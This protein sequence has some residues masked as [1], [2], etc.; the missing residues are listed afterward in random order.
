M[1]IIVQYN[2]LSNCYQCVFKTIGKQLVM[3]KFLNS[4]KQNVVI[5]QHKKINVSVNKNN[6][7][8]LYRLINL[9]VSV[10]RK[11]NIIATESFKYYFR[12]NKKL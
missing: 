7:D 6:K 5:C 3:I 4:L 12:A 8:Y 11:N 9:I 10:T 2:I 1:C